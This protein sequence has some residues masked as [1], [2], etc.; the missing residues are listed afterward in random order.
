M[1]RT[2]TQLPAIV[3][4]FTFGT[5]IVLA[6]LVVASRQPARPTRS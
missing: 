5:L 1:F 3:A 4:D 6:Q 2:I